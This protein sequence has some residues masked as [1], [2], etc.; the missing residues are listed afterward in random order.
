M[1]QQATKLSLTAHGS[2]AAN[3]PIMFQII[4]NKTRWSFD[5]HSQ[6]IPQGMEQQEKN[7]THKTSERKTKSRVYFNQ[8]LPFGCLLPCFLTCRSDERHSSF[9]LKAQP[10]A[11]TC[12]GACCPLRNS[13]FLTSENTCQEHSEGGGWKRSAGMLQFHPFTTVCPR[14]SETS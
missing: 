13:Q 1:W 3:W 8:V 4:S 6:G 10:S 14:Y 7:T 2:A 11:T 12:D 5:P 9:S